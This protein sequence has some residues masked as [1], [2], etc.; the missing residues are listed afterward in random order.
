MNFSGLVKL[1][2]LTFFLPS[3]PFLWA[4]GNDLFVKHCASCHT[5]GGGRLVG[6]DLKGV[7][8]KYP[9]AW[10]VEYIKSAQA[11]IKKKDPKTLV[12]QT[13]YG[14][15]MPDMDLSNDE[16]RAIL[17]FIQE[18]ETKI[19]LAKRK[20]KEVH[21]SQAIEKYK[22]PINF[23]HQLHAGDYKIPCLYCHSGARK[24]RHAGVPSANV[25]LNC[26]S[27]VKLDSPEI[28]KIHEAVKN[29][30][31]LIWTKRYTL[32]DHVYFNHSWHVQ[33]GVS[34]QKCHGNVEAMM[35]PKPI[36]V[37]MG[38]CI[39]CHRESDKQGYGVSK[40]HKDITKLD[41]ARCHH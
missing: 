26:H 10:L 24:S 2:F 9:E 33:A 18:E 31:P 21:I 6:S 32:P 12:L 38:W 39:H 22:Q 23:S 29:K 30:Q 40:Y 28:Q 34:C 20:M 8:L 7:L 35:K 15:V 19:L 36:Q 37:T 41:C 1:F 17:A 16:I 14:L 13:E 3:A 27:Q 11:M 4:S 5:V 25:C